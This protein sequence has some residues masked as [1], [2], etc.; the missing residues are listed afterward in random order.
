MA[1]RPQFDTT[2][3]AATRRLSVAQA[4]LTAA[5]AELP[6][7]G[8]FDKRMVTA[9]LR[10]AFRAV[11]AARTDLYGHSSEECEPARSTS[12]RQPHE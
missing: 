8:R 6:A 12:G 9:R 10:L 5:L 11:R 3:H 2:I 1:Q 7:T 4:E